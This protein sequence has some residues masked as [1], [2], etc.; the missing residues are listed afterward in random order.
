MEAL[1]ELNVQSNELTGSLP[2]A[3]AATQASGHAN[4]YALNERGIGRVP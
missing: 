1:V 2:K 4:L 3:L